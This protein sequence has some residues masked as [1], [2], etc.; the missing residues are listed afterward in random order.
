MFYSTFAETPDFNVPYNL[1][2]TKKMLPPHRTN[3]TTA[4]K[5]KEHQ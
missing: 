3:F 4:V 5:K 1:P 2:K